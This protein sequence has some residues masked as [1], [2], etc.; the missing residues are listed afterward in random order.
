MRDDVKPWSQPYKSLAILVCATIA[1]CGGGGQDL[2]PVSGKVLKDGAVLNNIAISMV[3]ITSGVAAIGTADK[4]GLIVLKTNGVNGVVKGRYKVA[5]SEPIREMT[6]EALASG[7]PPPMSFSQK[8]TSGETSGVEFEVV[9]GGGT[10]EF[11]VS[12]SK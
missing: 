7:K 2:E 10:F 11:D 8:F 4:S 12:S 1:G 6:P 9:E 5:F 3:P